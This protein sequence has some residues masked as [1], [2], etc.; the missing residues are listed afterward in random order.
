M[1][2][3]QIDALVFKDQAGEY[4]IVARETLER[5]RVPAEGRAEVER[6][7]AEAEGARSNDGDDAQGYIWP[8]IWAAEI[9]IGAA[10]IIGWS[11]PEVP[12][13]PSTGGG[14]GSGGTPQQPKERIWTGRMQ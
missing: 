14:S 11:G 12:T 6:L 8:L 1:S 5:G 3:E 10:I 4:F 13:G 9:A 7:I 2:D